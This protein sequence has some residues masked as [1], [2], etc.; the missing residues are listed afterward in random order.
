MELLAPE[1]L[2]SDFFSEGTQV[3]DIPKKSFGN[4]CGRKPVNWSGGAMLPMIKIGKGLAAVAWVGFP[5]SRPKLYHQAILRLLRDAYFQ[6]IINSKH[7]KHC[8]LL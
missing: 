7:H 4:L 1:R 6:S 5:P 8:K 3:K 2:C